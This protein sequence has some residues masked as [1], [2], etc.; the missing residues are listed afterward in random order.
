VSH[1]VA[2][3]VV[4]ARVRHVCVCIGKAAIVAF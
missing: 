1:H 2:S 3:F 4:A